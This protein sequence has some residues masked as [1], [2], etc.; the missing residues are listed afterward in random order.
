LQWVSVFLTAASNSCVQVSGHVSA[1]LLPLTRVL[2][3]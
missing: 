1:L 3:G 2:D